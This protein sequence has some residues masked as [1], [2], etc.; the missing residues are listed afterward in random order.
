MAK[1]RELS[2][3]GWLVTGLVIAL[4]LIPTAAAA[5]TF[6]T[7][8]GTSGN[9]ADVTA[10]HQLQTGE[11][12]P[13]NF[14]ASG[15]TAWGGPPQSAEI[16]NPPSGEAIIIQSI[17]IAWNGTSGGGLNISV[18]ANSSCSSYVLAMDRVEFSTAS[19]QIALS[20]G[21][22]FALPNADFLCAATDATSNVTVSVY[23]YKV[24]SATVPGP[25]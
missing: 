22:G 24:P 17:H 21:P 3:T 8:V 23:G 14:Y 7:I 19:G 1:I 12:S 20:Y 10:T 6:T 13:I 18:Q 15:T 9:K 5:V 16:A 25:A 4:I 2:R 11:T